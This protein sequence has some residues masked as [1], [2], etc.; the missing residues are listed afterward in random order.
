MHVEKV[1]RPAV[2]YTD[3]AYWHGIIKMSLSKFFILSVL[4]SKP[5]HGYEIARAVDRTTQGCCSPTE[6]TIYPV[7]R[8]FEEG[9]YVTSEAEVVSGRER[10][11]YTLTDKGRQAFKVGIDAW[12]EATRC[13]ANSEKMVCAID[14][15][16]SCC[17]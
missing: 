9:G 6:G 8:E 16:S 15:T 13:L 10:K 5:M 14:E 4:H 2:D 11:V 7:L 12:M 17:R 3:R 1:E